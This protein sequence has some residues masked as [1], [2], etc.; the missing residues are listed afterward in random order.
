MLIVFI[1]QKLNYIVIQISIRI[2]GLFQVRK[3]SRQTFTTISL[4][5]PLFNLFYIFF[6]TCDFSLSLHS[7]FIITTTINI[8]ALISMSSIRITKYIYSIECT[9]KIILR[10][11]F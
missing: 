10:V 7:N 5:T 9:I 11:L 8:M 4:R 1:W 2:S 3:K 6:L